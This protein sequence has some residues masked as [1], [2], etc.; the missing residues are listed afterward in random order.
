MKAQIIKIGNSHGIRIPKAVLEETRMSGEVEIEVTAEGILI[1]N[2]KKPRSDWDAAFKSL[3]EGDDDL[4]LS[5]P[6]SSF[7]KKDWQW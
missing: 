6:T 7:E 1:R 4:P 2:I 5:R 3:N